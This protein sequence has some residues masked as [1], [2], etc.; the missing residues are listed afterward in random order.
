MSAFVD[1]L[2]V[3]HIATADIAV[4]IDGPDPE[5]IALQVGAETMPIDR[6]AARELAYALNCALR[7]I[8]K[9]DW[10]ECPYESH[11]DDCDCRGMGGD[12]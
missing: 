12:R 3:H 4:R 2:K 11:A 7:R 9:K 10:S 6:D 5:P 1:G 8:R